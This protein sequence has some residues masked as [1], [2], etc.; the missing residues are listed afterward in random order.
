M[1]ELSSLPAA[2]AAALAAVAQALT[3]AAT[4]GRPLPAPLRDGAGRPLDV[5]AASAVQAQALALRL[6]L[7][8]R[9]VGWKVGATDP[10]LRAR[11]G[12]A[13]PVHGPLFADAALGDRAVVPSGRL[14]APVAEVEVAA[15]LAAPLPAGTGLEA[16]RAA[17]RWRAALELADFR[18]APLPPSGPD[19]IADLGGAG[20][21]ALA[22][23]DGLPAADIDLAG[24]EAVL[25][26]DGALRAGGAAEGAGA[27]PLAQ[28]LALTAARG[29]LAAG[30]IVLTGSVGAAVPVRPGAS[31]LAAVAGLGRVAV[32]LSG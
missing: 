22:Q 14:I 5:A 19:L 31:I 18:T 24:A 23:G 25:M 12:L 32:R 3:A 29:G 11:L 10:A 27:D 6:A 21:F 4:A 26:I 7:G 16:A 8:A 1:P 2:D 28:V 13:A 17:V 30:T 9:L 20:L 15:V